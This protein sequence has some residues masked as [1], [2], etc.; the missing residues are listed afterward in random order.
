MTTQKTPHPP[1]ARTEESA[2]HRQYAL[3]E[4]GK[5][6]RLEKAGFLELAGHYREGGRLHDAVAAR[7]EQDAEEARP[8]APLREVPQ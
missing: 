6:D 2:R 3:N 1:A 4:R 5:A 7:L 8:S